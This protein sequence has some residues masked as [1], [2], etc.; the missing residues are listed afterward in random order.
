MNMKNALHLL[1]LTTISSLIFL[2][3]CA[4]KEGC[5]D[6]AALNYDPEAE[7]DKGCE[8]ATDDDVAVTLHMHQNIGGGELAE[9][10][11]YTINGV[12]TDLNLVQFYV[13]GITLV[14]AAGNEI[15]NDDVYLLVT[16]DEEAYSIGNFP[17]GDYTQIKFNIGIDSVTNHADPSKYDIGNPL[18]AQ[19]PSMHW[20]WSFGYI[21]L[22][23]DGEADSDGNGVPDPDGQFEMH[24]GSDPYLAT[25]EIDVPVSIAE[26]NENIVHLDAN[27]DTFF[28]DVDMANDNTTHVTDNPTLAGKIYDNLFNM[29][30]AEE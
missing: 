19:F 9:E 21:F 13:S 11:S 29:F 18:G 27:W 25:I 16:P 6:Q 28:T 8:Y 30:S 14:D 10:S 26:G 22:R 7:V 3:S 1:T 4:K 2:S 17:A 20:G 12:V 15:T 24:L 5:M 23:I